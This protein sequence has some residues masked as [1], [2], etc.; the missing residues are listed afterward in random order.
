[1]RYDRI[2]VTTGAP[3]SQ[4]AAIIDPR[5]FADRRGRNECRPGIVRAW[6]RAEVANVEVL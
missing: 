3:Y 4:G 2:I 1:V 5:I 6:N